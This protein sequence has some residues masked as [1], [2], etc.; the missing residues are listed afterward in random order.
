MLLRRDREASTV[1]SV[2]EHRH[3]SADMEGASNRQALCGVQ[4]KLQCTEEGPELL[5]RPAWTTR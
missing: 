1:G 4:R 5:A 3:R 2:A